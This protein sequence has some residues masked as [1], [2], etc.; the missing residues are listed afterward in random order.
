MINKIDL[1]CIKALSDGITRPLQLL[2]KSTTVTHFTFNRNNMGFPAVF[3][4]LQNLIFDNTSIKFLSLGKT[5]L[6][7]FSKLQPR[8]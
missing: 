5:L 6:L 3:V 4:Q 2:A 1:S 8:R 7:M